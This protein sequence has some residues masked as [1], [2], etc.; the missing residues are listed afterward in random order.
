M[1]ELLDEAFVG[2]GLSAVFLLI[3]GIGGLV[4]DYALPHIPLIEKLLDSLPLGK[5]EE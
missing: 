5:K 4:S 1:E 2:L 3:L